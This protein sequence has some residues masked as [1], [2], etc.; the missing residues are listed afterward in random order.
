[1]DSIVEIN[2]LDYPFMKDIANFIKQTDHDKLAAQYKPHQ[3][4]PL[5]DFDIDF[6]NYEW[7]AV[8]SF[9]ENGS[10]SIVVS[11]Y[12]GG[13]KRIFLRLRV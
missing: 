12:I 3:F 5:Y 6:G 11:L 7:D 1:M 8:R 2:V 9:Q 4:E 13:V 10:Y